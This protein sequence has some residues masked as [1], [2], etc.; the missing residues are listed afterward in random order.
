MTV[1]EIIDLPATDYHADDIDERPSLSASIAHTLWSSSPAHARAAHPKLNPNHRPT[2]DQKFDVGTAAHAMLLEGRDVVV[3][4]DA[5]DWRTNAAKDARD[6][7]RAAGKVPLLVREL[8]DTLAMVA[9]VQVQL[10][11]VIA[12]PAVLAAGKPEQ[13]LVWEDDGVLCRARLDWLRDDYTAVEDLKTTSR[14]ANPLGFSRSLFGMGYDMKAAF[15]LRGLKA[16]TGVDAVF[17]WIVVETAAPYALSV[18]TPGPDVLA[19][20][21][22]KVEMA[23][24]TWKKCLATDDFP[25]YPTRVCTVEAPP[26]EEARFLEMREQVAA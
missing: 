19:I 4:V 13:T 10:D 7:A 24:A 8:D 16:V 6:A 1:A 2:H 5:P 3:A 23:I 12:T 17:R 15:Y 26:W 22:A 9:A 18:L 11:R 20:G 14:S 25:G 21:D